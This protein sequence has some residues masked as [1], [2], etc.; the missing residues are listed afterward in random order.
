MSKIALPGYG[1]AEEPEWTVWLTVLVA[2]LLGWILA[3]SVTGS[4]ET[5]SD[6]AIGSIQVPSSWVPTSED[7]ALIAAT[8]ID[9]G[10]Y[11][12]RV[13]VRSA[14]KAD[15]LPTRSGETLEAAAT[16]WSVL[17]GQ[18]LEGYRIL[19]ITETSVAGRPAVAI[20]YA[21]LTDPPEGLASGVMPALMHAIDTVVAS[22]DGFAILTVAVDQSSQSSSDSLDAL[23]SR[24]VAGWQVP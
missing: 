4:N 11:G 16:N 6:A 2:L 12:S 22:G 8:D 21:Y 17:R 23:N 14:S 13:S 10:S 20:E 1:Q 9:A 24:I 5:I 15:L 19:Q 3:T 7:G 18:N